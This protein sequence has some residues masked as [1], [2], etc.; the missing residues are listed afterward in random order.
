MVRKY[1]TSTIH[2]HIP[3]IKQSM[4]NLLCHSLRVA[5]SNHAIYDQQKKEVNPNNFVKDVQ[6]STFEEGDK[7]NTED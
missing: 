6:R 3:E 5:E 4:G 2:E 7:S 1:K